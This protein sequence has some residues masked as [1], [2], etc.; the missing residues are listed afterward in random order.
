MGA[1]TIDIDGRLEGVM[2]SG[3]E[4]E[5]PE[6]YLGARAFELFVINDSTTVINGSVTVFI[7]VVNGTGAGVPDDSTETTFDLDQIQGKSYHLA[8][9][10][11]FPAV[12]ST[13]ADADQRYYTTRVTFTFD[14]AH[15]TSAQVGDRIL[16]A[17]A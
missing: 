12:V 10:V 1:V 5:Q 17:W 11:N 3:F 13:G 6:A 7:D 8:G 2:A 14:T 4:P 9:L 15:R 16:V